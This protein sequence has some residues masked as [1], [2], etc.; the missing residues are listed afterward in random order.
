MES[1]K[2]VMKGLL[3]LCIVMPSAAILLTHPKLVL[4]EEWNQ[5]N[6]AILEE[7]ENGEMKSSR[8]RIHF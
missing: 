6:K 3:E 1:R 4:E 7:E 5:N 8:R 2:I